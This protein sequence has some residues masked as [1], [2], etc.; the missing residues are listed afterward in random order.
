[1][2]LQQCMHSAHM[3]CINITL[4]VN[5][6]TQAINKAVN[7]CTP[8]YAEVQLFRHLWY[9]KRSFKYPVNTM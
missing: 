9:E 3:I 4:L 1:M 5:K 8:S 6:K 7:K 2:R